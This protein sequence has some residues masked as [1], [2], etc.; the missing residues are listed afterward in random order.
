MLFL[1]LSNADIQ[2]AK[3]NLSR[4]EKIKTFIVHVTSLKL[5][6]M[7]IHQAQKDQIA[8]LVIEKMQIL[9]KYS[10]FLDVFSKKKASI[11]LEAINLNQHAIENQGRWQI[12]NSFLNLLWLF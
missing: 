10:D 5:N 7:L 8:L 4:D 3:K 2:F 9:S 12:K 6:L 1:T 11:L